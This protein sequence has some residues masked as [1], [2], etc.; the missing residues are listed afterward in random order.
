[1]DFEITLVFEVNENL[2]TQ[3]E[4]TGPVLIRVWAIKYGKIKYTC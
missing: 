2:E 3:R 1:M 4:S